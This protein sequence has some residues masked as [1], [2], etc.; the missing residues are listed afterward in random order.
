MIW[1]IIMSDWIRPDKIH[2]ISIEDGELTLSPAYDVIHRWRRI[3]FNLLRY[4]DM[5]NGKMCNI[6][7]DD[8]GAEFLVQEVGL[9]AIERS[10][11]FEH[12]H[13]IYLKWQVDTMTEADF[14]LDF[15][16]EPP[17]E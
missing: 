2:L 11:I 9:F 12:E 15:E 5:E 17:Q 6:A 8:G 13:E 7:V 1:A 14:G 10:D 3:G 4:W 16:A